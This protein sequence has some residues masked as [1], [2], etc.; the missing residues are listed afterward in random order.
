M[1]VHSVFGYRVRAHAHDIVERRTRL[2]FRLAGD[3]VGQGSIEL[4]DGLVIRMDVRLAKRWMSVLDPVL[5]AAFVGAHDLV[6]RQG[7]RR[8]NRW[9]ARGG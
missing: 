2:D 8:F 6:M 3:I 9:L 5:R 4:G 1:T 7:C